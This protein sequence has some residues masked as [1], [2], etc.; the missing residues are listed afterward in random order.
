[1]EKKKKRKWKSKKFNIFGDVWTIVF[2]DKTI[3]HE[4]KEDKEG[5]WVWGLED[6]KKKKIFI[7]TV[8][9]D[10]EELREEDILCTI[11]HECVHAILESGQYINSSQDEPMVEFLAK[12]I[13]SLIKSKVFDYE[14][15]DL[16]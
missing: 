13:L 4:N 11:A 6:G 12:G 7:S 1:M 5:H 9:E 14:T 2:C 3:S 16:G 10:G 8:D 15:E